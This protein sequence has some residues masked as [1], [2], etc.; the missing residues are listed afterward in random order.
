MEKKPE[1]EGKKAG[2]ATGHLANERTYLAWIRTAI[3]QAS[4]CCLS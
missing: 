1:Y 4:K 2:G 3:A